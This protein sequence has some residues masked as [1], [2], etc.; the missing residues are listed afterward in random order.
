MKK[1]Y[2]V[3]NGSIGCLPDNT[4]IHD[5]LEDAIES[6]FSLFSE[7]PSDDYMTDETWENER[8][9]FAAELKDSGIFYF[10]AGYG[11]D[12]VEIAKE[13]CIGIENG[14]EYHDED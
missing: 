9:D 1:H 6:V 4:E 13:D 3:M 8:K 12:Y 2:I 14:C 11:A 10:P 7:Y 5:S